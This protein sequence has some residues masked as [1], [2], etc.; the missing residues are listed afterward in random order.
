MQGKMDCHLKSVGLNF[1]AFLAFFSLEGW[2]NKWDFR[3]TNTILSHI[4]KIDCLISGRSFRGKK[5]ATQ[6]YLKPEHWDNRNSSKLWNLRTIF[7]IC[8]LFILPWWAD[9]LGNEDLEWWMKAINTQKL[10]ELPLRVKQGFLNATEDL[11]R[12]LGHQI[13]DFLPEICSFLI[14]LLETAKVNSHNILQ[15]LGSLRFQV[16]NT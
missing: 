5:D 10:S 14:H 4:S 13:Q 1:L 2:T 15:A 8:R 6:H 16:Q 9:H 11:L 7:W 3:R 12:H